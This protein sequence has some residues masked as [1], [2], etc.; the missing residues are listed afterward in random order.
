VR[1]LER[2]LNPIIGKSLVVYASKPARSDA[3][4][5]EVRD[6]AA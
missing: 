6:A 4:A 3:P 5:T 2:T 1:L